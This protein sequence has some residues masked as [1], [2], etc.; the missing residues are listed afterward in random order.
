MKKPKINL[1]IWL[2]VAA[3]ALIIIISL[4][5]LM[6]SRTRIAFLNIEEGDVQVDQGDGWSAAQDG[7]KLSVNDKVRTLEGSAVVV[8]Y[9]SVLVQMDPN[10]EIS[11]EELSKK[12]S[13]IHQETGSTWNKFAK[14]AGLQSFEVETPTTVATVRGTDFWVDMDSVGVAEGQVEVKMDGK[15]MQVKPNFKAVRDGTKVV[16]FD[17][18]DIQNA[19]MKKQLM[20]NYLQKIRQQE[21]EKHRNAYEM[22]KRLRGWTDADVQ[23]YMDRLDRGEFDENDIKRKTVLPIESI[24]KFAKITSE[25]RKQQAGINQL[26]QLSAGTYTAYGDRQGQVMD[27]GE[28]GDGVADNDFRTVLPGGSDQKENQLMNVMT[29]DIKNEREQENAL[30]DNIN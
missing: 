26:K 9:E 19:I 7:M 13:K 30:A 1:K 11:I 29:T 2:P 27:D 5:L 25:I 14:I 8:L 28:H 18:K 17:E 10:T 20:I 22:A 24:D 3:V 23:R 16:P 15:L 12:H 21:I 4:I 6:S